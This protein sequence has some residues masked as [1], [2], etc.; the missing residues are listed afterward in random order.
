M[1]EVSECVLW[2]ELPQGYNSATCKKAKSN[3]LEKGNKEASKP[4]R[5]RTKEM[6]EEEV[7]SAGDSQDEEDDDDDATDDSFDQLEAKA[8]GKN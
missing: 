7:A 5:R 8:N 6:S 4:K 3:R 2:S 1:F